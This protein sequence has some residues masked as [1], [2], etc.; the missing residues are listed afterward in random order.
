M[1]DK[2]LQAEAEERYPF[3]PQDQFDC[4]NYEDHLTYTRM[5]ADMELSRKAFI[6]GRQSSIKKSDIIK[7]L[8][9]RLPYPIHQ[10]YYDSTAENILQLFQSQPIESRESKDSGEGKEKCTHPNCD[11]ESIPWGGKACKIIYPQSQP[12]SEL[13]TCPNC[14]YLFSD[15]ACTTRCPKCGVEK[16]DRE[17][18]EGRINELQNGLLRISE[19]YGFVLPTLQNEID[20]LMSSGTYKRFV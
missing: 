16:A 4:Q 19:L 17:Q 9:D 13:I 14:G 10:T 1:T 2:A 12:D 6:A 8:V 20:T 3:M 15:I 5:V 7:V 11:C 18:L